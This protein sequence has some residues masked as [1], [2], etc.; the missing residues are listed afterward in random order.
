MQERQIERRMCQA[1]EKL[2]CTALKFVSPGRSGVPDRIV[3]CPGGRT[4]FI[5]LKRPGGKP[6]PLQMHA[7]RHLQR[8][9]FPCF[10]VS[11]MAEVEACAR[12]IERMM[13]EWEEKS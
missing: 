12:Q 9:G 6:R 5:E 4:I 11:T 7:I 8:L 10:V 2:G 1:V 13:Q 3:L